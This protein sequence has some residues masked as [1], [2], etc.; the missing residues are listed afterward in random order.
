MSRHHCRPG[1]D[2]L[3]GKRVDGVLWVAFRFPAAAPDP[4]DAAASQ[5]AGVMRQRSIDLVGNPTNIIWS[6]NTGV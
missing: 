3:G 5:L 6:L 4:G 1:L 2:V